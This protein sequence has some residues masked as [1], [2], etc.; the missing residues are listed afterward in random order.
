MSRVADRRGFTLIELLVVI[1][2]IGMLIG[3]LLP[4]VQAAREAARRSQCSNNLKQIGLALLN[5]ESANRHLPPAS[6]MPW[7]KGVDLDTYMEY[8]DPF[9]PNWAVL[10]L[11][12]IE[13]TGLYATA[14][15]DTFPG[16]PFPNPASKKP[17]V[18]MPDLS[19]VSLAW[20]SIV[21]KRLPCFLCP[22][23]AFNTQ[24]FVNPLVPGAPQP[25]GTTAWARGN[26]GVCA[27]YEDYDHVACGGTKKSSTGSISGNAGLWSSPVMSANYGAKLQD[28]TD[29]L[30]NT[31]MV[32]ELR[33]GLTSIDPRGIWA[34]GFPGASVVNAGRDS[35]N[36]SPNNLLWSDVAVY[37]GTG[38]L[39]G[40]ELED[41]TTYATKA[42]GLAGMG[43]NY[44]GELMTSAM[45]RSMHPAGVNVC[46]CDGSVHFILN[47][48][49]ELNWCRMQSKTDAQPI[50]YDYQ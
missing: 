1:A 48:I 18:P 37:N 11:P 21:A 49:D 32:C 12:Y 38:A 42:A 44:E 16:V 27:G 6:Q 22:S 5:F 30:S 26:Y 7:A 34:M 45:S 33:A 46:M 43:C 23:D 19:G 31:N 17:K 25:D 8:H 36:P 50:D 35:Y 24:P 14:Q 4:G 9:G 40:D 41:G 3:L 39:G 2:I 15:V 47:T 13:Q 28:I 10:I 20:R 29:G